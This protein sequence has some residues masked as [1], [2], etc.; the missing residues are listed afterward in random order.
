M[1]YSDRT[2]RIGTPLLIDDN[3]ISQAFAIK[4]LNEAGLRVI[5]VAADGVQG[6][7][8]ARTWQP[9]IILMDI[10]MPHMNGIE[11]AAQMR[12]AAPKSKII[13]V[14]ATDDPHVIQAAMEVG[15]LE[16]VMKPRA[17]RDLIPAIRR[18]LQSV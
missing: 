16:Y 12:D 5:E 14:S 4:H 15:G 11:A 18:A 13:F 9:N 2:I 7:A 1:A 6:V 17:G 3:A 10:S 8:K